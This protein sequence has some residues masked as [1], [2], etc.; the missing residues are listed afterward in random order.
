[1]IIAKKTLIQYMRTQAYNIKCNKEI[2]ESAVRTFRDKT[3]G[4]VWKEMCEWY[5]FINLLEQATREIRRHLIDYHACH[6][7]VELIDTDSNGSVKLE[8]ASVSYKSLEEEKDF[9]RNS[10]EWLSKMRGMKDTLLVATMFHRA[11]KIEK[12]LSKAKGEE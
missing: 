9:L 4:D 6:D 11:E 12:L 3:K 10:A 1:M 5:D 7:A 8:M 2:I